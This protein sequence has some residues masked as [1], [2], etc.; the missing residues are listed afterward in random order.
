MGALEVSQA[1]TLPDPASL[2]SAV[3]EDTSGTASPGATGSPNQE[4]TVTPVP[5]DGQEAHVFVVDALKLTPTL[6][7]EEAIERVAAASLRFQKTVK[8]LLQLT[9]VISFA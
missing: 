4:A 8:Q 7:T 5:M 1:H 6:A 2:V 9:R 3:V